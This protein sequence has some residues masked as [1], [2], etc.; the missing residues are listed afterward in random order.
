MSTL[1]VGDKLKMCNERKRYTIQAFDERFIVATKPHFETYYYTIIDREELIRGPINA[2]LGLPIE[3][4][5]NNPDGANELLQW[6]RDNG[7]Y[8]EWHVS[9]RNQLALTAAEIAQIG[10]EA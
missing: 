8:E 1:K 3:S 5:I 10:G 7:G 6:M 9:R 2:I 4:E